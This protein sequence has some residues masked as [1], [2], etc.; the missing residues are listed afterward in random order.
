[1]GLL[2]NSQR[3]LAPDACERLFDDTLEQQWLTIPE[4][5]MSVLAVR[6]KASRSAARGWSAT[7][8][9]IA[10]LCHQAAA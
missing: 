9:C 8:N 6:N 7:L 2:S 5:G 1:M 4:A 3:D 10:G